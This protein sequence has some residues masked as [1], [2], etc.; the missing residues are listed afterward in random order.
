MQPI[1]FRLW[2]IALQRMTS[3][4]CEDVVTSRMTSCWAGATISEGAQQLLLDDAVAV[5]NTAC[6]GPSII[7]FHRYQADYHCQWLAARRPIRW[8]ASDSDSFVMLKCE[9]HLRASECVRHLYDIGSGSVIGCI[10]DP[11][12]NR[13]NTRI[14]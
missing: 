6:C 12:K 5:A 10:H 14:V 1:W 13:V 7:A 11:A 3:S 9:T 8:R 4:H 2:V